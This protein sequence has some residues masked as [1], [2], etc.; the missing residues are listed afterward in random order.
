MLLKVHGMDT[1][2]LCSVWHGRHESADS[3]I[4]RLVRVTE[5]MCWLGS[6]QDE[7][8]R[9]KKVTL[10]GYQHGEWR[11][12]KEFC[13]FFKSTFTCSVFIK[14]KVKYF[15]PSFVLTLMIVAYSSLKSGIHYLRLF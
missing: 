9:H 3:A 13:F 1:V 8:L 5:S 10:V 4:F 7:R 12:E 14:H 6:E 2:L 15:N 11:V